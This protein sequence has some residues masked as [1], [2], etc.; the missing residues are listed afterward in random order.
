MRCILINRLCQRGNSN[1]ALAGTVIRVFSRIVTFV[2]T[3]TFVAILAGCGGLSSDSCTLTADGKR[4]SKCKSGFFSASQQ[5]AALFGGNDNA[6][7]Y[8]G[9]AAP[10]GGVLDTARLNGPA[11]QVVPFVGYVNNA[12]IDFNPSPEN[13]HRD[14][15]NLQNAGAT[16]FDPEA[17]VSVDLKQASI[18][19][20]LKQLL[21]GTL[22][23]NYIAP[24]DLG[25]SVTFRTEE[26]IPKSQ[27]LYVVRDILARNRLSMQYLNG[28]Y[29][30]GTP[31]VIAALEANSAQA[32]SSDLTTRV[33]RLDK[34][35][36]PNVINIASQLLPPGIS[37][38]QSNISNTII[39]RAPSQDMDQIESTLQSISRD[40]LGDEHVTVIP[41]QNSSPER[42]AAK[43]TAFYE[44]RIPAGGDMPSIIPLDRQR[45][46]LVAAR[47]AQVLNGIKQLAQLMDREAADEPTLR[48]IEL[49]HLSAEEI[50]KPLS[51]I[52]GASGQD[53]A[54]AQSDIAPSNRNNAS[55]QNRQR[56]MPTIPTQTPLADSDLGSEAAP[57]FNMPGLVDT[58]SGNARANRRQSAVDAL[59]SA[60][61]PSQAAGLLGEAA[62]AGGVRI[63]PDARTNTLM[64]YSNY[65]DFKRIRDVLLTMDVPQS[66]LVIEAM[67]VEVALNDQLE[68]GVQMYLQGPNVSMRTAGNSLPNNIPGPIIDPKGD[69]A[70]V[71]FG[72]QVGNYRIEAI[73]SALQSITN[74]K[75]ISS[76]YL[77]VLDGKTARLVVGDQIPYAVSSQTSQSSGNVTVTQEIQIKDTGIVLDVTPRIYSSNSVAMK[78]KQ[79]VSSPQPTIQNGN[80]V[81]QTRDIES[82]VLGQSGRTIVLGGLIQERVEKSDSGVPVLRNAP[83]IGDLFNTRVDRAQR[84]ELLVMLTPRVIRSS[85][86]IED[87]TR[88]LRKQLHIR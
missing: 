25:G 71:S 28:V 58:G 18:N 61:N 40:G 45:A 29:H 72:G 79:S 10:A 9:E 77:T 30:I 27:L 48:V 12:R 6:L 33:V 4:N 87:I 19:F 68:H 24:D 52:F 32:Q 21:G 78:I 43:L 65:A 41:T 63:V 64:V 34:N 85:T 67:I 39:V 42:L 53:I 26:P 81:I 35:N 23:V 14:V 57:R 38:V 80:P 70:F 56:Q 88:L 44:A 16:G 76:P 82:N 84:V 1:N 55:G 83:I 69:T 17:R 7:L 73:L 50:A 75:V 37:L 13:I 47:D 11:P 36:A 2:F 31:E 49:R 22:G 51:Q 15:V 74:V 86:Q 62:L 66:Q 59:A 5:R 3:L 8:T 54:L 20:M 60:S 46:L